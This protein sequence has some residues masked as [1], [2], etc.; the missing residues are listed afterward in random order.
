MEKPVRVMVSDRRSRHE[1]GHPGGWPLLLDRCW[2]GLF[3]GPAADRLDLEEILE[4]EHAA[5]RPLPDFFMPP[6]GEP[7]LRG[8][9]FISTMPERRTRAMRLV[10]APSWVWT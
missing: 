1:K 8:R 7:A 5:S 2:S 6:K 9:P 10:R 3:R 4:P